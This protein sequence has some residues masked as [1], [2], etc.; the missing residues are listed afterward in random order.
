MGGEVLGPG[1]SG[2][3]DENV[4][5]RELF[6]DLAGEEIDGARSSTSSRMPRIPGLAAV[7]SSSRAW[8]RPAM[9]T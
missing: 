4:E 1:D 2:V 3:V 8:R 9:I 6:L 7:I 5:P